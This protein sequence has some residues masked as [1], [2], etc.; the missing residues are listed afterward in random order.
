MIRRIY[1][2]KIIRIFYNKS[3]QYY[4]NYVLSHCYISRGMKIGVIFHDLICIFCGISRIMFEYNNNDDNSG[5][6]VYEIYNKKKIELYL[7]SLT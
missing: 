1:Y 7:L 2:Q 6:D 4:L 3:K 5:C